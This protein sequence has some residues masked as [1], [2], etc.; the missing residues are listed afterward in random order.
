MRSLLLLS[1]STA[2]FLDGVQPKT[3]YT[4]ERELLIESECTLDM[5]QVAFEFVRVTLFGDFRISALIFPPAM[6]SFLS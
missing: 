3:S 1:L 6:T 5:S 4:A 2:V